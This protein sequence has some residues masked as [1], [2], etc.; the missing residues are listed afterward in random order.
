MWLCIT[1][2]WIQLPLYTVPVAITIWRFNVHI[3]TYM[4]LKT[5]TLLLYKSN[6][7]PYSQ[8]KLRWVQHALWCYRWSSICII[9]SGYWSQ[10]IAKTAASV[11][12]SLSVSVLKTFIRCCKIFRVS[13]NEMNLNPVGI[14]CKKKEQQSHILHPYVAYEL[15]FIHRLDIVPSHWTLNSHSYTEVICSLANMTTQNALPVF[16]LFPQGNNVTCLSILRNS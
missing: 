10:D 7:F 11:Q 16:R 13:W 12:S 14:A 1:C 9:T 2:I 5:W 8:S 4:Q 15:M 6:M 3:T